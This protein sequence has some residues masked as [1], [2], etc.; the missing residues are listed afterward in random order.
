MRPV[1]LQIQKSVKI[2]MR[3]VHSG[4]KSTTN[5]RRTQCVSSDSTPIAFDRQPNMTLRHVFLIIYCLLLLHRY[6]RALYAKLSFV[7]RSSVGIV[8]CSHVSFSY[9]LTL[10]CYCLTDSF[11]DCS[12]DSATEPVL[13]E[14]DVLHGADFGV[15]QTISTA[16]TEGEKTRTNIAEAREYL[17]TVTLPSDL[18]ELCRNE[19]A[20]C[21]FWA[22]LGECD[23]TL[24]Q[25][26][27][28]LPPFV[29]GSSWIRQT[30]S[31]SRKTS[32]S[33]VHE[34][35]LR[36]GLQKLRLLVHR[37]TLSVGP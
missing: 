18:K 7:P 14:V 30:S 17:A 34:E 23:G 21:S 12:F 15:P 6:A 27:F 37:R 25:G 5:A 20:Q 35:E 32:Q 4:R 31:V 29:H 2:M 33:Q 36:T 13:E 26:T 3:N 22:T 8:M 16:P 24:R 1:P 9:D 10:T 11:S 28:Y 19:H